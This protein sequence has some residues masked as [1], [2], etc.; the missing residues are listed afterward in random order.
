ML[1][2]LLIRNFKRFEEADVELGSPAVFIGP[3]NS[4]KTAAIQALALWEIG[5][6]RWLERRGDRTQ[7]SGN[8]GGQRPGVTVNRRDL[9]A[10][11][12]PEARLLWTDLRYQ[13]V[14]KVEG[15]A[16][17][18]PVRIEVVVEGVNDGLAWTCGVE[19]DYSNEESV[20]CRPVLGATGTLDEGQM[21]PDEARRVQVAYLPPMSGLTAN[22][23]RIDPGAVAVRV[24]EGRTAEVLRNL[25]YTVQSQSND[26]WQRI[27][28]HVQSLFGV[29]LQTPVYVP[30]RGEITIAYLERGHEFDLSSAGRG[31]QQT[32][33]LLAYMHGHKGSVLLLDE[34]DAHLEVL[35]QRQMY[36]L[37][38]DE[39]R[40]SGSQII[41]ASH[42]EV[43]L[44]EA[45]GRDIVV[46]FTGTPHRIDGQGSQA[47]KSL[48]TIGFEHYQQAEQTGWVLYLEGSTD[49]ALLQ[50]LA[51]RLD[52]K[53]AQQAMDR[54]FVRYVKDQPPQVQRHF[55][56][57]RDAFPNLKGV[58]LFDRLS[59]RPE[60][61]PITS[62]MWKHKEIE[63]Y[64]CTRSVL[65]RYA[66]STGREASTVELPSETVGQIDLFSSLEADRRE[67]LMNR[68]IDELESALRQLGRGS[69]WDADMKVSDEFL[70]PL[71]R[72]YFASLELP[73]LM[74]KK[75]FYEL[76]GYLEVGE[77]DPEVVEKLDVIAAVAAE[78]AGLRT[79]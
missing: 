5:L 75:S 40:I 48:T 65:L 19:F 18:E 37:L 62:L 51:Q 30:E 47:L 76:A 58:A 69:P 66:R 15:K 25:C 21:V 77:I 53:A 9:V 17:R 74:A 8:A 23:T 35:R 13:R 52:H 78:A 20:R 22:E 32:L 12:V 56:G 54:P 4:G 60:L 11:P 14:Y 38:T 71:F 7:R 50:S 57:L 59:R 39:A 29:E 73:N 63:N 67:E 45:A 24:G 70:T 68:C 3:N 26:D 43:W 36:S 28:G 61:A 33:L 34:P 42:S 41:A 46:A 10:V 16:K 31:L 79:T 72:N 6:K 64:V 55:H 2:R 44:N 49:L 27:V 1:T